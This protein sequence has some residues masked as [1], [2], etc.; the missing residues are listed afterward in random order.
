M[1]AGSSPPGEGRPP[2][3]PAQ[4]RSRSPQGPPPPPHKPDEKSHYHNGPVTLIDIDDHGKCKLNPY[5]VEILNQIEGKLGVVTIAGLYRTGKSYLLNRLLGLQQGFEIGPST[6]PCTKGIWMWGQPVQVAPNFHCIFLDTEGLGSFHRTQSIDMQIIC[7]S[8]LLASYFIYNSM[9]AIDETAL[10]SLALVLQLTKHIHVKSRPKSPD[11]EIADLATVFPSFLWVLRDFAL[12]LIDPSTNKAITSRDY[13]ENAL[14]PQAGD[15]EEIVEKNRIRS[16]IKNLFRD[17]DCMTLVRPVADE[18]DL[19]EIQR[20]P[21][22]RLRPQFKQ[23]VEAF[24][25]KVYANIKPKSIGGVPVSGPML[26]QLAQEYVK[27]LNESAVPTISTAWQSVMH[28]QLRK[29]LKDAQHTYRQLM[30]DK[31]M[32]HLPMDFKDLRA[33]HKES[34]KAA[35]KVF[36]SHN[37]DEND[38]RYKGFRKE[39]SDKIGAMFEQVESENVSLSKRQAEQ[40]IRE[41]YNKTIYEKLATKAYRQLDELL[42]DWQ[43]IHQQFQQKA[44]GPSSA[45]I[46]MGFGMNL[47]VES[48]NRV[49][50]DMRT[51]LENKKLEL[52][53]RVVELEAKYKATQSALDHERQ[54]VVGSVHDERRKWTEEKLYLEEKLDEARRQAEDMAHKADRLQAQLDDEKRSNRTEIDK[55]KQRLQE[56]MYETGGRPAAP[57]SLRQLTDTINTALLQLSKTESE[58]RTLTLQAEHERQ[59][60]GLERKFQKQVTEARRRN[61]E[62][63]DTMR[64]NH[65]AQVEQLKNQNTQLQTII[66][67]L[68]K[69]AVA[70]TAEIDKLQ[71]RVRVV[72]TEKS[73]RKDHTDLLV[74]QSEVIVSF[75]KRVSSDQY[76]MENLRNELANL[77]SQMP[78]NAYTLGLGATPLREDYGY[79]AP[80]STA[81][82][83]LSLPSQQQ[84]AHVTTPGLQHQ[85]SMPTGTGTGLHPSHEAGL[86]SYGVGMGLGR[87]S[88]GGMDTFQYGGTSSGPR[89]GGPMG[90][91]PSR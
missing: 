23:Q 57:D 66:H 50:Q 69:S 13:L 2:Q 58:K 67:E 75:L 83:G 18:K 76:R 55:Y 5:A 87:V 46:L 24:V 65:D 19:R 81:G 6:N 36:E 10:D 60:I 63:L 8:L 17:R 12:Q 73:I 56:G 35:L 26:A 40:L 27:A 88:S 25:H 84:E 47:L 1:W 78:D 14:Q 52:E 54:E 68:E 91:P 51:V 34:K 41:S 80:Y 39:F 53:K 33:L 21:Y 16:M 48:V 29:C 77:Q 22:D 89:T 59:L 28:G 4:P 42:K 64:Q 31:A 9:K 90:R 32:Q 38:M 85:T 72:E 37:F 82:L 43:A 71:E 30:N 86:S 45:Q 49:F 20:V 3:A 61:D 44:K 62:I 74:R 7:L 11:A 70:K 15:S 79:R